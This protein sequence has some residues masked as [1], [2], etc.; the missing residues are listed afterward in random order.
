[1][2]SPTVA[3]VE[4]ITTHSRSSRVQFAGATHFAAMLRSNWNGR[5]QVIVA[6]ADV[7]DARLR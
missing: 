2:T 5:G 4:R 6:D 3:R 7:A 1:M